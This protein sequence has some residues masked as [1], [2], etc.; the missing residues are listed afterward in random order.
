MLSAKYQPFCSGLCV[1]IFHKLTSGFVATGVSIMTSYFIQKLLLGQTLPDEQLATI[2]HPRAELHMH[3]LIKGVQTGSVLGLLCVGPV[4]GIVRGR[5]L[6][7]FY[8]GLIQGLRLT[9]VAAIPVAPLIT[10]ANLRYTKAT[11]NDIYERCCHLRF[12]ENECTV[13]RTTIYG[14][15][16]FGFGNMTMG[17]K[18]L[19]GASFG[20]AASYFAGSVYITS[21]ESHVK[22]AKPCKQ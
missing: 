7:G 6:K 9:T 1:L 13:A 17:S 4:L 16:L 19:T 15:L 5:S 8:D 10:E 18:F 22:K 21:D 3:A 12:D 20:V 2:S 14:S 11:E